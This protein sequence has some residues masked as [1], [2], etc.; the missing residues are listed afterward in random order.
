MVTLAL[1]AMFGLIGLAV[2]FGWAFFVE[3]SA[4]AA[5][6]AAAIAAVKKAFDDATGLADFSCSGST[7]QC[8]ATPTQCPTSGA[9]PRNLQSACLYAAQNGFSTANT[10]QN[11]TVAAS[12]S[13]TPPTVSGCTPTVTH[14]PT[15]P[16]VDVEYWVTVRVS[17]SIPQLFSA[18]MGNGNALVSARAT[19]A[20]AQTEIIGSLILINRENDASPV[21]GLG[22]NLA[23]GGTPTVEVPGGILLA[24]NSSQ[25]GYINGTGDVISPFTYIRNPGGIQISGGGTWT[26][27]PQNRP[28]AGMF[29]DPM[30][31][32]GQPPIN[33]NT[34]YIP[35]P[36]GDLT[37][38]QCPGWVCPPGVYY[39]TTTS[40]GVTVASG[41]RI[42]VPNLASSTNVRF[43]GGNFDDYVF[44]G[45]LFVDRTG[46]LN[47]GP[48]R[49]VLAGV[50]PGSGTNVFESTN[51]AFVTGGTSE[52]SDAGRMF[53]LTDSSYAG[54]LNTTVAGIPHTR[55][56]T[57]LDFGPAM[58]KAGNN[59]SS[60]MHL[61]GLNP[62]SS[63]L[64]AELQTFGPVVIWQDQ[65][66]S[67]VE[68]TST[69]QIDI[70]CVG[71]TLNSPCTNTPDS[72]NAPQLQLHANN[73]S[74]FGGVVYQPRGAWTAIQAAPGY[75][76]PL[77]IISGGMDV[78]GSGTLT[79][80]SPSVP[81][82]QL[83]TALVE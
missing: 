78:Q 42:R 33:P 18:I 47:F 16:C 9:L 30:R 1:I 32:K 25:A 62:T 26:A 20:V 11:V 27:A 12:D 53:I 13:S 17:E 29:Q 14:P 51:N 74:R 41:E 64:P 82:T 57:D 2:D 38:T 34:N 77:R 70:S 3:K 65:Q 58:F 10:R 83:T 40:G 36:N 49:Y 15:A 6:D 68:Y 21:V 7:V 43:A 60:Q 66:N 75:S 80:T 56:W 35:V 45:G 61:Y 31:G 5:A 55:T 73:R 76:G 54:Q 81:V 52:T 63:Y 50:L 8:Y 24:S 44:F 28:D 37:T 71:A 72:T 48:G 19:A 23:I 39:A 59:S 22:R 79:L 67:Y 46:N 69:G 4:Q